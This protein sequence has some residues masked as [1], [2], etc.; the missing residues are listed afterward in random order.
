MIE[1]LHVLI[2]T[3][4]WLQH[5][6]HISNAC[7]F[8]NDDTCTGDEIVMVIR[9]RQTSQFIKEH[10][11]GKIDALKWDKIKTLHKWPHLVMCRGVGILDFFRNSGWTI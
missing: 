9:D 8:E 6:A 10:V 7:W 3:L 5:L 2:H 1:K 11:M 4:A